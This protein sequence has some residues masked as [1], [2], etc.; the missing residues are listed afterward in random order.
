[1]SLDWFNINFGG[2]TVNDNMG[3]PLDGA[4]GS[5]AQL[6]NDGGD[7]ADPATNSG[8]GT[9]GNDTVVGFV[10]FFSGGG[11]GW[12]QNTINDV[13]SINGATLFVRAWVNAGPGAGLAPTGANEFYG[14]SVNNNTGVP[15]NGTWV[16]NSMDGQQFDLTSNGPNGEVTWSTTSTTAAIPEPTTMALFASGAALLAIRR[17]RKQTA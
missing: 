9:T 15:A 6:I 17:R 16:V 2:G 8:D 12:Y 7:G 1:M 11:A 3:T 5:W 13:T 4:S 10:N 14:D